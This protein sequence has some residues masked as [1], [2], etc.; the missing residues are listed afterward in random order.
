MARVWRY[1]PKP[2]D[3]ESFSSWLA[4]TA[5]GN[6][7]KLHT[8]SR[9]TWPGRQVWNRDLDRAGAPAMV[10]DV[11]IGTYVAPAR[12]FETCLTRWRGVMF[13]R[14]APNGVTDWVCPLGLYHRRRKSFGQ[15]FCPQCLGED[16]EPYFRL[17]WRFAW[18]T[19]C[20]RHGCLLRDACSMCGLPCAP[21]RALGG[22]CADC[23]TVLAGVGPPPRLAGASYLQTGLDDVRFGRSWIPALCEVPHP[24]GVFK[25]VRELLCVL[26]SGPR[27]AA[28][29]RSLERQFRFARFDPVLTPGRRQFEALRVGERHVLMAYAWHLLDGW[30]FRFVGHC[31]QARVWKSWALRDREP[32]RLPFQLADPIERYVFPDTY[33]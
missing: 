28:L 31:A 26:T 12:A 27:S 8:F 13:E 17:D 30:P 24:I 9:L 11:A 5:Y 25:L 32:R 14:V 29:R 22:R 10:R 18:M 20:P 19:V 3:D 1:H 16:D 23:G 4:R 7:A 33:L 21:H 15:Q 6:C 2:K